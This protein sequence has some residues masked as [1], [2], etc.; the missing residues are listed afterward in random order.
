[1][2]VFLAA[3]HGVSNRFGASPALH[4]AMV[5]VSVSRLHLVKRG[6]TSAG[7][8]SGLM[9]THA[10]AIAEEDAFTVYAVEGDFTVSKGACLWGGLGRNC[11]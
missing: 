7:P 10:L 3:E 6:S 5:Q 9:A 1:M 2:Y 8:L 4:G 11:M